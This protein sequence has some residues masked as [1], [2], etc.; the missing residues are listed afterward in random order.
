VRTAEA[1]LKGD[2]QRS[3]E[4]VGL[5]ANAAAVQIAVMQRSYDVHVPGCLGGSASLK[6]SFQHSAISGQQSAVNLAPLIEFYH[7]S[8]IPS[9][10]YSFLYLTSHLITNQ[11]VTPIFILAYELNNS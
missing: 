2:A 7:H 3:E 9:F 4:S 8:T 6:P 5:L 1:V 11:D 10:H